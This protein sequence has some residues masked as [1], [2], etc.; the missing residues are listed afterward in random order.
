M[1]SGSPGDLE[2]AG[3][4]PFTKSMNSGIVSIQPHGPGPAPESVLTDTM[5]DP[6]TMRAD[7]STPVLGQ[8]HRFSP[9]NGARLKQFGLILLVSR[10]RCS[11]DRSRE[12][13]YLTCSRLT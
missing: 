7:A 6:G 11:Q 1:Q 3:D 9:Q 12:P 13:T 4:D 10:R 5:I 2:A 8:P